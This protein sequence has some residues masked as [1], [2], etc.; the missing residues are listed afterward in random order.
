[1]TTH[2]ARVSR[3]V[4]CAALSMA[5][6][7]GLVAAGKRSP[8]TRTAP[9]ANVVQ[10]SIVQMSFRPDPLTITVGQTVRW[11]NNDDRDYSILA[12]DQSFKSGNLRPKESFEHKF[13][14]P[15]SFDYF[16]IFRPR[17]T[18]TIVVTEKQ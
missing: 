13:T 4:L 9:P 17:V 14:E 11:T 5:P 12:K 18:G 3:V 15:G 2:T 7:A 10:V 16:D 6:L 8:D 1:M